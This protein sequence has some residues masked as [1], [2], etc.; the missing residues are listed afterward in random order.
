MSKIDDLE[1]LGCD[2][3]IIFGNGEYDDAI[4]GV[5]TDNRVVYDFDLMVECLVKRDN[6]D[7]IEAV[8]WIEYNTIRSLPYME[9]APIVMYPLR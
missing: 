3:L 6:C 9:G 1:D 8:E 7:E 5:T 4:I 2:E